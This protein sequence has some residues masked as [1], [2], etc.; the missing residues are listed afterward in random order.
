MEIG[1]GGPEN[2]FRESVETMVKIHGYPEF[3]RRSRTRL[4]GEIPTRVGAEKV[5]GP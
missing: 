2:R 5:L 1:E 4:P 3:L